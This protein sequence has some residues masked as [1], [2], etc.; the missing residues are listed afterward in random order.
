MSYAFFYSAR[1]CVYRRI[2][3]SGP[4][5]THAFCSLVLLYSTAVGPLPCS[6]A[7]PSIPALLDGKSNFYN[8]DYLTLAYLHGSRSKADAKQATRFQ[9][10]LPDHTFKLSPGQCWF[11]LNHRLQGLAEAHH[12]YVAVL[13]A[14][15][16][17]H[18]R[19][20]QELYVYRNTNWV[21]YMNGRGLP[22][23]SVDKVVDLSWEVFSNTHR[24]A[25]DV[26]DIDRILGGLQWHGSPL[27]SRTSSF[28]RKAIW[29]IPSI[30][31]SREATNYAS[32]ALATTHAVYPLCYLLAFYP[33]QRKDSKDPLVF[34]FDTAGCDAVIMGITEPNNPAPIQL[35]YFVIPQRPS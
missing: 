19:S 13:I 26:T 1:R 5:T 27:G 34:G 12:T 20:S 32:S 15:I 31:Y 16:S 17:R 24:T 9:L 4:R 6:G 18:A 8:T 23:P 30:L 11:Q 28:D 2:A 25:R 7:T 35:Y 22:L 14:R 29:D 21:R 33:T 3:T 10:M